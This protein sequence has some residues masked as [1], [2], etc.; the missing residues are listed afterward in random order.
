MNMPMRNSHKFIIGMLLAVLCTA[1]NASPPFVSSQSVAHAVLYLD[2]ELVPQKIWPVRI[3]MIDGKLTNRSDQR[4]VW[5]QP[6]KYSLN[7]KL[8]K[9]V[10]LAYV[11]GLIKKH[12][13]MRQMHDLDITVEAGKAYYLVAKF[14]P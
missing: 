10:N 9:V 11:P 13:E 5:I 4:E 12:P 1:A 2:Y 8:T 6:G 3:W 14:E 7:M